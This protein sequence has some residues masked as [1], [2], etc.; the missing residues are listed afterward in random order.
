M[1]HTDL[2]KQ[3][4]LRTN[5]FVDRVAEKT[6]L[7]GSALYVHSDLRNFSPSGKT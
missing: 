5:P 6:K 1:P 2:L 7:E 4:N 3:F